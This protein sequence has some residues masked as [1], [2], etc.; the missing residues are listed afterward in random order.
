MTTT[1]TPVRA[2]RGPVHVLR[3]GW[4][5]GKLEVR[6][7]FRQRESVVFTVALPVILL[8]IFAPIFS[9]QIA[10]NIKYSQYFVPGILAV[11]LFGVCFQT[12]GIQ[13]AIERDKGIL[14]RLQG[15]PMPPTAY[16]VGKFIMV[17][18]L[19]VLESV[20]LLAIAAAM[21]KVS[22][23]SDWHRWATFVW[24]TLAGTAAG[25]LLG[26][27]FSSVPRTGRAAPATITPVALIVS[28]VS[29]IYFEFTRMPGWLQHVGAFFPLKWIAQ[30]YRSVFLPDSFAQ[31]EPAHTWEHGRTLLIL[32]VWAVGGLILTLRT[33]RWRSTKDS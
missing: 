16:F 29:G 33:F 17:L 13:I 1:T 6:E 30:G 21:G 11:G 32:A 28:F 3:I 5:R 7:F 26:I 23:P 10:G 9:Y 14:K 27:A 19:V 15:T 12:L 20:V 4:E 24:V 25:S 8:V 22:L 2:G 31:Q 18:A